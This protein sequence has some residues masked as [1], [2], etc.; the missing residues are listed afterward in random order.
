MEVDEDEDDDDGEL[1]DDNMDEDP[2]EV[3]GDDEGETTLPGT[4]NKSTA[5]RQPRM[6]EVRD[7]CLLPDDE[8]QNRM[9][10]GDTG[11]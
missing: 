10:D 7:V 5:V 1:E 3:T 9:E 2:S 11:F 4:S 8:Q 6:V